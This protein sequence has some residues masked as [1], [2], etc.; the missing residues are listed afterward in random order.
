MMLSCETAKYGLIKRNRMTSPERSE[1]NMKGF[2]LFLA[3][4]KWIKPLR[5]LTSL[6][7]KAKR[8]GFIKN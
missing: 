1:G 6:G 5:S 3:E 4:G 8:Q 7:L 2:N